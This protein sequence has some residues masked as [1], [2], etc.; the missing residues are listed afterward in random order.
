MVSTMLADADFQT[1]YDKQEE[2]LKKLRDAIKDGTTPDWIIT[3]LEERSR[4]P[5]GIWSGGTAMWIAD[6]GR[7]KLFA[8][9]HASGERLTE[10]DFVLHHDNADPRGIWSGGETLWVLDGDDD[11]LFA[12][13]F[14]SGELLAGYALDSTNGDPHGLFFDGVSFRVSDQGDDPL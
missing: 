11:A 10:Q 1:D 5:R 9:D 4:A 7:D 3:A 14:A 13:A 8:H 6:S 12:Y 2:E